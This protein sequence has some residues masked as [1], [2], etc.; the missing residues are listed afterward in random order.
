MVYVAFPP[1]DS[2]FCR[3]FRKCGEKSKHAEHTTFFTNKTVADPCN[4]G[5][6]DITRFFTALAVGR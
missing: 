3:E 6:V 4:R 5:L 2:G 1:Q